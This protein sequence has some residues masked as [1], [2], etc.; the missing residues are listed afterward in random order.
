MGYSGPERRVHRILVTRNTEYHMRRRTVVKVRDRKSGRWVDEHPALQR[1]LAG[2][3]TFGETD[4][5]VNLSDQP[6]PG[7][8]AFFGGEQGHL[9]TSPVLFVRRPPKGL[10]LTEYPPTSPTSAERGAAA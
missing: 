2:A 3:F 10:V 9:I 5:P 6:E 8:C 7:E 1:D 4:A